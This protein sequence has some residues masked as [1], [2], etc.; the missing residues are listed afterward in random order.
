MSPGQRREMVDREHPSLPVVRQCALLGVSRSSLYYRA[1]MASEADLTMMQAM[2][3]QYLETLFYGSRRMKAWLDRNGM[4]VSRKRVQRL[5]RIMGLR[6]IYRRPRTS[7]PA[8]EH[9]VYPY[10]LRNARV[11]R[12]NQVW[13]ADITYLPMAR[14]FLYLVAVMDWYSR[15][16]VAWRLSNTL[17]AGFCTEALTEALARGRPEVFNTDQGSQFS[18][19][20]FTQVLQ[21]RGV[22]ISMDGKGGMPITSSWSGCG[23]R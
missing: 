13:A 12:P 11:T 15:Y 7:Q 6:A 23:V 2:D 10:L 3:R 4:P 18:S 17:D 16:V 20:E 21:D 22:K 9:R 14:G 5:M 8:P 1:K 19:R